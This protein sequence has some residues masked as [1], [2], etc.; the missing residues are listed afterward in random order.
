MLEFAPV[1]DSVLIL[2]AEQ[3]RL[4]YGCSRSADSLYIALTEHLAT[5]GP[6]ELLTFDAGLK[7]QAAPTSSI[8]VRVLAF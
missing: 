6:A 3:I 5:V 4:N 2:R 1:S 7:K 8:I